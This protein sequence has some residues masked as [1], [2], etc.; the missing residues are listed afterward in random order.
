MAK[1]EYMESYGQGYKP[2][3]GS[4]GSSARGEY[5]KKSNPL[6]VPRKGSQ[7]GSDSDYGMNADKSK[8]KMLQKEQARAESLRGQGC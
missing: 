1:M 2:P 4:A 8:V 7:I 3:K 6:P 5:S